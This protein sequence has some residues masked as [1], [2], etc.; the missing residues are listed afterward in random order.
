MQYNLTG[1]PN[2]PLTRDAKQPSVGGTNQ[3]MTSTASWT[4]LPSFKF[5]NKW[6]GLLPVSDRKSA[7]YSRKVFLG[8]IPHGVTKTALMNLLEPF[9]VVDVERPVDEPMS[10]NYAYVVFN[11]QQDV[12]SFLRACTLHGSA[13]N[14]WYY[15]ISTDQATHKVMQVIPWVVSDSLYVN[16]STNH[17]DIDKTVFVGGLHGKLSAHG[18]VTVMNDLFG[19]VV[20]AAI[21]T[22]AELKYPLGSGRVTFDNEWSFKWAVDAQFITIHTAEFKSKFQIKPFCKAIPC[23]LCIRQRGVYFDLNLNTFRYYCESCHRSRTSRL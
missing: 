20:F 10:K 13:D 18:L 17:F 11:S 7:V 1:S 21:N 16:D 2:S 15:K 19:G 12:D 5:Q 9:N 8:G 23:F 3:K 4:K 22:D 14:R 6:S